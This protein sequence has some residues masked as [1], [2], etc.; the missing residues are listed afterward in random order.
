MSTRWTLDKSVQAQ[1]AILDQMH[2]S[3]IATD[4]EGSIVYWNDYAEQQFQW[5]AEQVLGRKY[6][7]VILPP[8]RRRGARLALE[9][10]RREGHLE[11]D[12]T[13]IRRDGS[14]FDGHTVCTTLRS[15]DGEIIG[16]IGVTTDVTK[17]RAADRLQRES[18]ERFR[19]LAESAPLMIWM[20]KPDGTIEYV[21][22]RATDITGMS[23]EELLGEDWLA[24]VHPDDRD[25]TASAYTAAV[26]ERS[27]LRHEFRMQDARGGGWVWILGTV[28]PRSSADGMF[29][30]FVGYGLDITAQR[31]E[32]DERARG[33]VVAST[34]AQVGQQ[35]ISSLNSANFL[36][37]LCALSA[38]HLDCESGHTLLLRPEENAF[39]LIAGTYPT[40]DE[41]DAA[42]GLKVPTEMMSVL[43]ERLRNREVTS[44]GTVPEPFLA[45]KPDL[46]ETGRICMALRQGDDLIGIQTVQR[47]SREP[48]SP[49]QMAIAHGIAQL[50]S[51]ALDHARLVEELEQANSVK[52]DF[53]ATMSH[54]LRT[55]LHVILG[56]TDLLLTGE[57]GPLST[58][59][60]DTTRRIDRRS[61]ELHDLIT[62]TLDV[63]RLESGRVRLHIEDV[64]LAELLAEVDL[65]TQRQQE[66]AG[67]RLQIAVPADL[68][69]LRSDPTKLKV[70]V[71]NLVSNA[72]KFTPR[73]TVTVRGRADTQGMEI[74][75]EDTGIG[76]E[77]EQLGV[78][79]EAF[80]QVDGSASRRHGGAGLGLYIVRR[81]VELLGGSITVE[82]EPGRGSTF[83][84]WLP[85][86]PARAAA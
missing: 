43:V 12:A 26:S 64:S 61:R 66:D 34:L 50:A 11:I 29:A 84:V 78:I 80:Q 3:V 35:L 77:E 33:A 44:V 27:E 47:A 37:R 46:A 58:E 25:S 19:S 73:G 8:E 1:A 63:S 22:S 42:L 20:T 24:K 2:C 39:E 45:L 69:A 32:Q 79:F 6:S 60:A 74:S 18:E 72:L 4:P 62:N 10:I 59:Q 85:H 13:C 81:L 31:R 17:E 7:E 16:Q 67:V 36:D 9:R 23:V 65:E 71:K 56:Y 41:R 21:N 38:E 86:R 14:L 53:V 15:S 68:P 83:R 82:S 28:V 57:F 75:V 76:I 48:F 5:N 51:L 54:E 55:P 30:G 52:S 49:T 40:V 70:V